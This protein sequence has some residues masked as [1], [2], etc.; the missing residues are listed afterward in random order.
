M[1]DREL[2]AGLEG[3]VVHGDLTLCVGKSNSLLQQIA[4]YRGSAANCVDQPKKKPS[5]RRSCAFAG[6]DHIGLFKVR[7]QPAAGCGIVLDRPGI[8]EIMLDLF[9]HYGT[10]VAPYPQFQAFC[11]GRRID[12]RPL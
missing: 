7:K 2:L 3:D 4:S 12:A 11:R 1:A 9:K 8:D 5:V 6:S 10:N